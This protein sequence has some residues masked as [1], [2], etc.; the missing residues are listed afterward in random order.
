MENKAVNID[1]ELEGL[2]PDLT[3]RF[4]GK[5][6]TISMIDQ[7]TMQ[8]LQGQSLPSGEMWTISYQL[9]QLFSIEPEEFEG[10]DARKLW[11]FYRRV[12]VAIAEQLEDAKKKFLSL[13]DSGRA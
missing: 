13:T 10:T 4:G 9:S 3:F 11:A 2:F 12:E 8:V 5:D 1:E 6:Y 7:R